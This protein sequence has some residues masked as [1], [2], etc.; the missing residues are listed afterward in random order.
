M[1][2]LHFKGSY[3]SADTDSALTF[4]ANMPRLVYGT[5]SIGNAAIDVNS[6]DGKINY[7]AKFDTL[8]TSSNTLFA[9]SV[10]GAAANDSIS[11]D[12][13]HTGR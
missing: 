6:R 7:E 11:L 5:N 2:I 13:P 8:T 12:C 9:T 3:R 4:N 1:R 10:K